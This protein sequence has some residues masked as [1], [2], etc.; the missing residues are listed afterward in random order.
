MGRFEKLCNEYRENKRLMEQLG[1]DCDRLKEEIL[2][3]MGGQEVYSEG[4]SKVTYKLIASTRFD[5][6]AF[7]KEHGDLYKEYSKTSESY[8]FV[9][10]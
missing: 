2:A 3:L 9:V 1:Q 8:R 4:A 7:K 5:S 6:A 10:A